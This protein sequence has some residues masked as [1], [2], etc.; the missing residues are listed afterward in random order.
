MEKKIKS[1]VY[2]LGGWDSTQPNENIIEIIYY[3]DEE[4][5]ALEA[6]A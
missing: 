6:N 3:T 5:A 4:L 1:I 2:G